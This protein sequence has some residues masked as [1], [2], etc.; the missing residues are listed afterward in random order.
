[1]LTIYKTK[2]QIAWKTFSKFSIRVIN[3]R[4]I[5]KQNTHSHRWP[6]RFFTYVVLLVINIWKKNSPKQVRYKLDAFTHSILRAHCSYSP[7]E[8]RKTNSAFF[9][10]KKRNE[11]RPKLKKKFTIESHAMELLTNI[12]Q[13]NWNPTQHKFYALNTCETVQMSRRWNTIQSR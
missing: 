4:N 6:L 1:M 12:L 5:D 10:E 11:N 2:Y 7:F 13:F 8:S 9:E 3:Y